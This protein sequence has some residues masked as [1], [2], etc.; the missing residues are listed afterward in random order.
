MN[1]PCDPPEPPDAEGIPFTEPDPLPPVPT[2]AVLT[3]RR[4]EIEMDPSGEPRLRIIEGV[5]GTA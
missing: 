3:D 4:I 5:T 1:E 2:A